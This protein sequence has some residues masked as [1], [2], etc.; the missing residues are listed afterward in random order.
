MVPAPPSVCRPCA[1][2][3]ACLPAPS[4]SSIAGLW[5]RRPGHLHRVW[6]A[7]L[8]RGARRAAA[9]GGRICAAA[10]R[11]AGG[12]WLAGGQ[13]LRV[14]LGIPVEGL[15]HADPCVCVLLPFCPCVSAGS[16]RGRR[17]ALEHRLELRPRGGRGRPARHVQGQV[18]RERCL[19]GLI[20]RC[21]ARALPCSARLQPLPPCLPLLLPPSPHTP[22]S[23][24]ANPTMDDPAQ[25]D[26]S[27]AQRF[28]AL[29]RPN[30]WPS[31]HVPALEGAFRALGGIMVACGLLLMGHCE[32][33][34]AART[35]G[36]ALRLTD[37]LRQSPCHK[38]ALLLLPRA[39]LLGCC[40]CGCSAALMGAIR[41][42]PS[43]QMCVARLLHPAFGPAPLLPTLLCRAPPALLC[44][45]SR[46]H[47]RHR[48]AGQLVWLVSEEHCCCAAG[49]RS[50]AAWRRP[51][52]GCL[53]A[54]SRS[55]CPVPLRCCTDHCT[56]GTMTTAASR[57]CVA[58]CT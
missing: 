50:R 28:P 23:F 22:R 2:Q 46:R 41:Q 31:A 25:G 40:C 33:Y 55:T 34:A 52:V 27:L 30:V 39:L 43:H 19:P 16:V 53:P 17:R 56:A 8:C 18:R 36:A 21:C 38:G 7:G 24:Y 44:C 48:Q 42:A 4:P 35:G 20:R 10:G 11:R 58:P 45:R 32:R 3:A 13:G 57:A 6:C 29:A 5:P 51:R 15:S 26:A 14:A 12:C 37:V 1:S 54:C 9:A 49:A 47:S